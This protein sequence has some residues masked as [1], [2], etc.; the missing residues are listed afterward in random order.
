MGEGPTNFTT[1][2]MNKDPNLLASGSIILDGISE[3]RRSE[4]RRV[5]RTLRRE[6]D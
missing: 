1:Y 3:Y 5:L 6:T 2:V 4:C